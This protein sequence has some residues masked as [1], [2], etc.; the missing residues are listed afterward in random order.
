MILH[1]DK[2]TE[3][4]FTLIE[5]LVGIAVAS[6]ML[7]GLVTLLFKV[8]SL[9]R[10]YGK[11]L[12]SKHRIVVLKETLY[13][14]LTL[15]PKSDPD[16]RGKTD[17]FSRTSVRRRGSTDLLTGIEA[18][19]PTLRGEVRVR[20][21]ITSKQGQE[22]LQRQSYFLELQSDFSDPVTLLKAENLSIKYRLDSGTW[23]NSTSNYD[24][25]VTAMKLN[26]DEITLVIPVATKS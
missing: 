19:N 16:F 9:Q 4:G 6:L 18:N 24:Q 25:P 11:N 8:G 22:R 15:L 7:S 26:S 17:G 21:R 14:D 3:S 2:H 5:L 20:Y 1:L 23:R 13:R 10:R 12:S